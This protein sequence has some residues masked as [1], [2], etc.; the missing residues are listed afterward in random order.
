[1]FMVVIVVAYCGDVMHGRF[2]AQV[3]AAVR[4]S[5]TWL[6]ERSQLLSDA[7]NPSTSGATTCC[8]PNG[9]QGTSVIKQYNDDD[10]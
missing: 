10:T 3:D 6:V 9:G 1:M 5:A 7:S 4:S 8:L 2:H